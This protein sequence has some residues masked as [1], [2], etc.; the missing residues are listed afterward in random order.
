MTDKQNI[1]KQ[2]IQRKKEI[3]KIKHTLHKKHILG[4]GKT[5]KTKKTKKIYIKKNRKIGD[6]IVFK[7]H[8][9]FIPNVTPFEMFEMGVFGGTYW[10]P[11][12]SN[13]VHKSLKNQHREFKEFNIL[14]DN[15]LSSSICNPNINF[16]K[17]TAGSSLKEWEDNKWIVKQDPYG[18]VQWYCRFYYGK[19]TQDDNR[20]I[21]RWL[22]YAGPN[23]RF[24]KNLDNQIKNKGPNNASN[25]IKQGLLQWAYIHKIYI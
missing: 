5:K 3:I 21:N 12:Y 1:Q 15:Y 18:W 19:R 24:K 6:I 17:V 10:R 23:G 25:T 9:E 13:I 20:Q 7:D 22:K 2:N 8:P 14:P 16:F 4:A 11:I